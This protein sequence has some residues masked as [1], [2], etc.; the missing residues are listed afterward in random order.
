[1]NWPSVV[2]GAALACGLIAMPALA[3]ES[4]SVAAAPPAAPGAVA[5]ACASCAIVPALTPVRLEIR[6]TLGSAI[7]QTGDTFP[8]RLATPIMVDGREVIPAGVTGMGEVVH[9]KKSGGAGAAGELV[10]AA[11][12]LDVNGQRLRLRSLQTTQSGES[13][14][15]TASIASATVLGVFGFLIK[16][17]KLTI[18]EGSMV[19]AK[20]AEPF[21]I[22]PSSTPTAA[23]GGAPSTAT[24]PAKGNE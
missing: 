1:M 23:E 10:L 11:R 9:A 2:T 17:G 3:Q 19:Q 22:A 16:G 14:I 6:A 24:L 5:G 4:T 7:S 18:A 20:T 8:F 21:T 13:R 12:Y 15:D